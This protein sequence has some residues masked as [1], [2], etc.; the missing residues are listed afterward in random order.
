MALTKVHNRMVEGGIINVLDYGA[1]AD[2][3]DS[4]PTGN[5]GTDNHAAFTAALATGRDVYVP[6]GSYR[7]ADQ[8]T[9]S[10]DGQNII[11]DGWFASRLYYTQT[12]G[13][14]ACLIVNNENIGLHHLGIFNGINVGN[15]RDRTN[16]GILQNTF[17]NLDLDTIYVTGFGYGMDV[18]GAFA[19]RIVIEN[20]KQVAFW[21]RKGAK[22]RLN[23]ATIS[24]AKTAIRCGNGTNNDNCTD[25]AFSDI[26]IEH[27]TDFQWAIDK[28]PSIDIQGKTSKTA[29][30]NIHILKPYGEAIKIDNLYNEA[31]P[32]PTLG[33]SNHV[34]S[35]I[36]IRQNKTSTITVN[37]IE[38]ANSKNI[39]FTNL[40]TEQGCIAGQGW[41]AA[42]NIADTDSYVRVTN[43]S[44]GG[45]GQSIG[46]DSFTG[47]TSFL[48]VVNSQ[49]NYNGTTY[50][51]G[52]TQEDGHT[53][54]L[55]NRTG[56]VNL[57]IDF[58]RTYKMTLTG[59]VTMTS[60]V[61]GQSDGDRIRLIWVQDGTGSHT[62]SFNATKWLASL[63]ASSGGANTIAT[64][65][66]QYDAASA[67]FI[68]IGA[69]SPWM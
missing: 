14:G 19:Q 37:A 52:N 51:A 27:G 56:N 62:V 39:C 9:I 50:N 42:I 18:Q 41:D 5:S 57:T 45:S 31:G 66:F 46:N 20:T 11:G 55:G 63:P 59:G 69:A 6:R 17:G 54:N 22:T 35:N 1:V 38:V 32:T 13:S 61:N 47:Q 60:I 49:Y 8:L 7:L 67:K 10:V 4:D 23:V 64:A 68:Q 44:V 2:F 15:A 53:V 16:T 48:S 12:E 29:W 25:L 3:D 24:G 26:V 33:E 43:S 58:G 28:P 30:S 21:M 36:Q 65:I 40:D 34:F